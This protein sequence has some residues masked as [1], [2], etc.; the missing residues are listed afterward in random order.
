M[1]AGLKDLSP[2]QN[3][4]LAVNLIAKFHFGDLM[5]IFEHPSSEFLLAGSI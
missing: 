4:P 5:S 3:L 1:A 2:H